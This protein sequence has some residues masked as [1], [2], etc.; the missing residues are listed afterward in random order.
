[1]KDKAFCIV[2]LVV[3]LLAAAAGIFSAMQPEPTVW[4]PSESKDLCKLTA[5][6]EAT[7]EDHC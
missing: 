3:F 1:M 2:F 4:V 6:Y 5:L 7:T